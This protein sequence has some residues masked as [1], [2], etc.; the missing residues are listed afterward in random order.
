MFKYR[1]GV[2]S[3]SA[4]FPPGDAVATSVARLCML[5]E[6]LFL[7]VQGIMAPQLKELDG[8]SVGWRKV[9]FWRNSLRTLEEI[10][11]AL[12]TLWREDEFQNALKKEPEYGRQ[13]L[14]KI[15][16]DMEETSADFLK[17]LRSAIGGHLRHD[18]VQEALNSLDHS[19]RGQLQLGHTRADSHFSFTNRLIMAVLLT[20][21]PE[22]EQMRRLEHLADKTSNLIRVL[23]GIDTVFSAYWRARGLSLC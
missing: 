7:E 2:I 17:D 14:E 6:D 12:I 5:R 9:Y 10:R 11:S 21:I 19:E 23:E 1:I 22:S 4:W 13:R 18:P 15:K 20:G 16:S 3:F 8:N